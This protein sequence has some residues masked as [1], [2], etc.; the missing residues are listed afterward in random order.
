VG[1]IEIHLL[2][3]PA[4]PVRYNANEPEGFVSYLAELMNL[5]WLD[6]DGIA[7]A[8]SIF[9]AIDEEF[10]PASDDEDFM[11]IGV[12]IESGKN[13]RIE[14]EV[15]H[16]EVGSAELLQQQIPDRYLIAVSSVDAFLGNA[17]DVDFVHAHLPPSVN[18]AVKPPESADY[19]AGTLYGSG[20]SKKGDHDLQ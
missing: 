12:L 17:V 16:L 18:N 11:F 6:Q 14:F 7:R 4:Y 1:I 15:A 13:S 3:A 19:T 8:Q 9:T 2:F 10:P 20:R 5:I